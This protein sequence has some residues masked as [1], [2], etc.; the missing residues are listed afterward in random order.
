MS[1]SRESPLIAGA[2]RT[3][4]TA[5]FLAACLVPQPTA[6]EN[7]TPVTFR[8]D[9]P[10]E[11][12]RVTVAG[13]FNDWNPQAT[14]MGDPQGNGVWEITLRLEPGT[15]Q[16]KFVANGTE[17][18]TDESAA[19]FVPDG[20]GGRN[21]V[22]HVGS[23]PLTVGMGGAGGT[24]AEASGTEVTFRFRPSETERANA[25]S[26]AGSFDDW[27]AA[28]HVIKDEDGDGVW[29]VV[30]RLDPGDHAY[31]FVVNGDR[32]LS[33]PSATRFEDDGFGGRNALLRVETT[34]IVVGP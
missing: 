12:K 23:E 9:P 7:G 2:C 14:P 8:F 32:W 11:A 26:V 31:Q 4:L 21:S 1:S 29:E 13:T 28:A 5:L 27:D 33:D 18:F 6:G 25:V 24:A 16:Y 19:E 15:Y 17:W 10:V 34:P 3:C 20:F 30:L 22:L